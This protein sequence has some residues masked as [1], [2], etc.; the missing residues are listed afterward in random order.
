VGSGVLQYLQSQELDDLLVNI[1]PPVLVVPD[2]RGLHEMPD[3]ASRI[4]KQLGLL[5]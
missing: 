1:E 3:I 2:I 4:N 5:E